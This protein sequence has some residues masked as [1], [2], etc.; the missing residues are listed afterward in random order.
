MDGS[1]IC[2]EG[3]THFIYWPVDSFDLCGF[4]CEGVPVNRASLKLGRLREI[5]ALEK[6]K[7]IN[8]REGENV[9]L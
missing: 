4:G 6:P 7:K 8:K 2:N 9:F 1:E 5:S 3:L